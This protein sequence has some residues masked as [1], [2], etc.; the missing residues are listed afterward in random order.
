MPLQLLLA[1]TLSAE[2]VD[3]EQWQ[4]T[5]L[6]Y[7]VE[8]LVYDMLR[9]LKCLPWWDDYYMHRVEKGGPC[10]VPVFEKSPVSRRG[11]S[12]RYPTALRS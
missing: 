1:A 11:V 12:D 4:K 6:G 9:Q 2:N 7:D 10:P 3:F 5:H 8:Q